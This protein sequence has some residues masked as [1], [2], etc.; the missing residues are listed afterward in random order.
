MAETA[1]AALPCSRLAA[2]WRRGASVLIFLLALAY[3]RVGADTRVSHYDEGLVN[4]AAVRIL[5]GEVP[6]RDFWAYHAPGQFY[7]VAAVFRLFGTTMLVERVLSVLV[8]AALVVLTYLL[9]RRLAGGVWA[10]ATALSLLP[11]LYPDGFSAVPAGFIPSGVA[12]VLGSLLCFLLY[13]E[14]GGRWLIGAG[15]LLGL[16]MLF[17]QDLGVYAAVAE[18]LTLALYLRSHRLP[19]RTAGQWGLPQ[20]A[21]VLPVAAY[22]LLTVPWSDLVYD[23][24]TFP[25]QVLPQVRSLPYPT[26]SGDPYPLLSFWQLL[27]PAYLLDKLPT[28]LPYYLP[29]L[30]AAG[31]VGWLAVRARRGSWREEP[32]WWGVLVVLLVTVISFNHLRVRPGAGHLMPF[33]V[34][35]TV[36]LATGLGGLWRARRQARAAAAVGIALAVVVTVAL[37]TRGAA[38]WSRALVKAQRTPGQEFTLPRA[39][40]LQITPGEEAY[41]EV[42]AWA[43]NVVPPGEAIY[44]GRNRHD[45]FFAGDAQFYFLAERLPATRYH[46]LVPGVATTARVQQEIIGEL[47]SHHTRY[48][49]LDCYPLPPQERIGRPGS[50]LLDEYLL[51]HFQ[52]G[53]RFRSSAPN[54]GMASFVVL[55][56]R[57]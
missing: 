49:F 14:R 20:L 53:L 29:W 42:I 36:L 21:L 46:D 35:G 16:A 25:L 38:L 40:G 50:R 17:R 45:L 1:P 11:V 23:F 48:V 22:F 13:L 5:A 9:T 12:L 47:E 18:G 56:R 52:P 41:Q 4:V 7:L 37:C 8:I 2:N 54:G 10:A 15:A 57:D 19:A 24:V 32:V 55:E 30:A 33:F 6:Y 39:R 28:L 27:N 26:F 51:A 44:V 43:R 3:L 34:P 31:A